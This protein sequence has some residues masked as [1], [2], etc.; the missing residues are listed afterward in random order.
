MA[1]NDP[2]SGAIGILAA[3]SAKN[4]GN[5]L[6]FGAYFGGVLG[7]CIAGLALSVYLALSHYRVHTDVGFQSFCA[8]SKNINCDTVSQSPFSVWWGLPLAVWGAAAYTFMLILVLF[9]GTPSAGRRR[10]WTLS[11]AA[12]CA[13]SLASLGFAAI[14][15]FKIG[16]YC[17]LCIATYAINFF[18]VFLMWIIRRRFQAEEL[19]TALA[20]DLR[21]LWTKRRWSAPVLGIL[22][23]GLMLAGAY[24]PAYWKIQPPVASAHIQT[25][26]TEDGHPWIGAENPELEIV[27]FTDYQCFQCRKMHHYL[28]QVLA[29][30]PGKIR[31]V[32]RHFPVDHEFNP[33]VSEPF[34]V[35]SGR[36]ALLAIHAAYNG[37]FAEMNDW[38]FF[39]VGTESAS[40]H[41]TEAAAAA[42]MD[43]DQLS[44]ALQHEP[45]RR[46]L[47]KDIR[48]GLKLGVVGTPSYLINGRIYQGQLP[49]EMLKPLMEAG[50]SD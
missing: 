27:E 50:V 10:M 3:P 24:Y 46:H 38:L 13:C 28:L 16:S 48:D 29:R 35:G 19:L 47:M 44:F 43:V 6:P 30:Y 22:G 40:I 31:V 49:A 12:A 1:L 11:L 37:K 41:L 15:A 4:R 33:I 17:I 8:L 20:M 18:L 34:H 23:A 7:L 5:P 9:S 2:L 26:L 36:M 21:F 14:S 32:Q 42:G 25:G 45:Y 39:K